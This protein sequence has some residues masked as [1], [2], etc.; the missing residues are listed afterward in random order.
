MR[1]AITGRSNADEYVNPLEELRPMTPTTSIEN[2]LITHTIK[3]INALSIDRLSSL[4]RQHISTLPRPIDH[5][6][7][8]LGLLF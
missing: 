3:E 8:L 2:S 7:H 1:G 5:Q 6:H 4:L